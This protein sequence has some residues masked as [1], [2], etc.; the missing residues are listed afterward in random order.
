MFTAPQMPNNTT[1]NSSEYQTNAQMGSTLQGRFPGW[2]FVNGQY[3]ANGQPEKVHV[4]DSS[5]RTWT[6]W[7]NGDE[8][9]SHVVEG[10][11]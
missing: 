7:F 10:N 8:Q 2:S 3:S 11:Q 1:T 4:K 5:G 6:V 9:I